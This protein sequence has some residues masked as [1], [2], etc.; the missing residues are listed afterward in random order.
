MRQ[1]VRRSLEWHLEAILCSEETHWRRTRGL[2]VPWP[3]ELP[4]GTYRLPEEP[5]VTRK[6]IL[7]EGDQKY[8]VPE[9][10]VRP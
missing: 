7:F 9:T 8:Y 5:T 10:L 4:Q 2:L 1:A 6:W 3:Y